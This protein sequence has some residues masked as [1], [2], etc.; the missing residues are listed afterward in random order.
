MWGRFCGKFCGKKKTRRKPEPSIPKWFRG[1]GR[2]LRIDRNGIAVPLAPGH[3]KK[4]TPNQEWMPVRFFPFE[5]RL[6]E[7]VPAARKEEW[8]RLLLSG[9]LP[10]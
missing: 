3:E 7:G 6:L 10:V 5:N 9:P 2:G 1:S 4:T 8:T